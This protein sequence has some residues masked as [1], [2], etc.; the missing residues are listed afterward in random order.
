[1][2]ETKKII[3][4]ARK[5]VDSALPIERALWGIKGVGKAY[6]HA[7][8][9]Q[10]GADSRKKVADLTEKEIEKLE[11]I[12]FNPSKYDLPVWMLNHRKERET[13]EDAHYVEANLDFKKKIDIDFVKKLR[14]WRGI[15][16]QQGQPVR[17]Q[18]TKSH[19]RGGSAIGVSKKKEAPGKAGG[20][21]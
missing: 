1:M 3:R 19:F 12:I 6:A 18:R 15:R 7:I 5:D 21:K 17:G 2:A 9:V 16:H 20:K 8:R 14:C 10:L 11:D 4:I 13:G